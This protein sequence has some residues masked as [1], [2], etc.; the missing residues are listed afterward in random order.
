MGLRL[1]YKPTIAIFLLTLAVIMLALLTRQ[2][3]GAEVYELPRAEPGVVVKGRVDCLEPGGCMKSRR[4]AT[5]DEWEADPEMPAPRSSSDYRNVWFTTDTYRDIRYICRLA[6]EGEANVW[7]YLEHSVGSSGPVLS[8]QRV[9]VQHAGLAPESAPREAVGEGPTLDCHPATRT[10]ACRD[11]DHLDDRCSGLSVSHNW[12]D[13]T[14]IEQGHQPMSVEQLVRRG[15]PEGR[16]ATF[17]TYIGPRARSMSSCSRWV[18]WD[19]GAG[20]GVPSDDG[21]GCVIPDQDLEYLAPEV[22][23]DTWETI[24]ATV[25]D[26]GGRCMT[27]TLKFLVLD[28]D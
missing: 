17:T 3:F 28:T 6:V 20:L 22:D 11:E 24:R 27:T 19:V 5:V 21:G 25:W 15:I 8:R 7:A 2:A 26:G 10:K 4:C 14:S 16:A 18:A 13:P 9:E 12:I 23:A 1:S